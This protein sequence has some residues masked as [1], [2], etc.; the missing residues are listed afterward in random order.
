MLEARDQQQP[1]GRKPHRSVGLGRAVCSAIRRAAIRLRTQMAS[2][3]Q[4]AIVIF[5]LC[6]VLAAESQRSGEDCVF[7]GPC[8]TKFDC[9]VP[10]QRLG[11]SPIT[12]LC[13][14]Y[15]E[16]RLTCCCLT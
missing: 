11:L 13:Q 2:S 8:R 10:C 9:Y 16:G 1:A 4:S 3:K 7:A 14:P 12:V 5:F 6:L 15:E